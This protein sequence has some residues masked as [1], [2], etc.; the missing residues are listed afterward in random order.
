MRNFP[1]SMELDNPAAKLIEFLDSNSIRMSCGD[2]FLDTVKSREHS[3]TLSDVGPVSEDVAKKY[4]EA[5]KEMGFC[6]EASS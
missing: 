3:K 6:I 2:L 1:G 5:W 4:I